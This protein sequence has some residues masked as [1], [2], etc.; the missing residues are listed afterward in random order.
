MS[1]GPGI[2]ATSLFTPYT[3]YSNN[4]TAEGRLVYVNQGTAKDLQKL[5]KLNISLN[6]T[7]L[8]TRDFWSFFT[9]V[10][11]VFLFLTTCAIGI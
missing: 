10:C 1:P 7:I 2:K 11:E 5:E 4:G 8:L 9:L 3:A 6:G